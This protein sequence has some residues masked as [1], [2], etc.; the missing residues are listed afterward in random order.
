MNVIIVRL[1]ALAY[2]LF[3]V[4]VYSEACYWAV[5]FGRWPVVAGLMVVAVIVGSACA[6][7]WLCKFWGWVNAWVALMLGLMSV[8]LAA[9]ILPV[10]PLLAVIAESVVPE[11]FASWGLLPALLLVPMAIALCHT[12]SAICAAPKT[13]AQD[14]PQAL[15]LW[16]RLLLLAGIGGMLAVPVWIALPAPPEALIRASPVPGERPLR[17][18]FIGNSQVFV[19]DVPGMLMALGAADQPPQSISVGTVV[20]GGYS[21]HLHLSQ[22]LAAEVIERHGPWD[23]VVLQEQSSTPTLF[24]EEMHRNLRRFDKIIRNAGAQTVILATWLR[25]FHRGR[26]QQHQEAFATIGQELSAQVVPANLAWEEVLRTHPELELYHPDQI[27]ALPAGSYLA[28][29]TLYA[30]LCGRD[31]QRL[32]STLHDAAGRQFVALLPDQARLLQAAAWRAVQAN[33]R[34]P[35]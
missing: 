15:P 24:P 17:V 28:A 14:V 3:F 6:G 22:G 26:F 25:P 29:C 20:G 21:L 18:L 2:L 31:P 7:L 19:N 30:A 5:W 32:P 35:D 1:L 11:A 34:T 8:V 16:R 33:R 4:H 12:A 23:F 9:N 27:H 10:S 13:T